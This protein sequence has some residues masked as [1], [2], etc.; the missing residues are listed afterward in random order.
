MGVNVIRGTVDHII[1][2]GT[3]SVKQDN[4]KWTSL[5]GEDFGKGAKPVEGSRVEIVVTRKG[6]EAKVLNTPGVE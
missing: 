2:G 1:E 5:S 3:I 4:G 6:M